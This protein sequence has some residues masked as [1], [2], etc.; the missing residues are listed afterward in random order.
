MHD[1]FLMLS[2]RNLV[3]TVNFFFDNLND[4]V[5]ILRLQLLYGVDLNDLWRSICGIDHLLCWI[6]LSRFELVDKDRSVFTCAVD[7][8]A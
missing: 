6:W 7:K 1:F 3:G 2:L 4:I 8:L 5:D